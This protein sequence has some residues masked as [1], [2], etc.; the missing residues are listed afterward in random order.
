MKFLFEG[1]L[2]EKEIQQ[3]SKCRV[4]IKYPKH[5]FMEFRLLGGGMPNPLE[6]HPE[7]T[8]NTLCVSCKKMMAEI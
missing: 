3:C 8:G 7:F 6:I 4:W 5:V 1:V 2:E